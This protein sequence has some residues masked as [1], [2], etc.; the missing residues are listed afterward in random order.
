MSQPA[1]PPGPSPDGPPP[2]PGRLTSSAPRQASSPPVLALPAPHERASAAGQ[3]PVVRGGTSG[4]PGPTT[5]A[6]P[7]LAQPAGTVADP[8]RPPHYRGRH[9]A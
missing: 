3:P 6:V 2:G 4:L 8:P 1:P 7:A 5:T 9:R